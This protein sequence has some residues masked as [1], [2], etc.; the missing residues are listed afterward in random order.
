MRQLVQA[1]LPAMLTVALIAGCGKQPPGEP[2][3]GPGIAPDEKPLKVTVQDLFGKYRSN[4]AEAD[5]E[6]KGKLVS[7]HG[8]VNKVGKSQ[9]QEQTYLFLTTPG[10]EKVFNIACVFDGETNKQTLGSLSGGEAITLVG[11]VAGKAQGAIQ[12]R[13]CRITE[14]SR[15]KL[16]D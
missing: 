11:R 9:D 12:V 15:G 4:L 8:R 5:R 16:L 6:F 3:A 14:R 7:L 2:E 1:M 10:G 13:H